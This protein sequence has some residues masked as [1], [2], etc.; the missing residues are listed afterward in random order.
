MTC[1]AGVCSPTAAD[2]MLNTGD[3]ES[4]LA[5][6]NVE[7]TITGSGVPADDIRID[8]LVSWPSANVLTLGCLQI[9][10]D[11]QIDEGVRRRRIVGHHQ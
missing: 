8:A 7:V 4:L 1:A 3:L 5:S 9:R 11:G 2:A 6:R 10:H